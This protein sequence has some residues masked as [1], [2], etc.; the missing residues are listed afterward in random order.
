MSLLSDRLPR[1]RLG[2]LL[3]AGAGLLVCVLLLSANWARADQSG[4]WR[5]RDRWWAA[6]SQ[7]DPNAIF[8]C[9]WDDPM[10]A[11]YY[12]Q[13]VEGFRKDVTVLRPH[14]LWNDWYTDLIEDAELRAT[15]QR[16]W[17]EITR[18][19]GLKH[20]GTEQFWEGTALFAHRLA[21]HYHGRRTVY[22]LHGPYRE[23]LPGPPYFVGLTDRLY[24]LDFTR[25]NL[26]P[27]EDRSEPIVGFDG[28]IQLLSLEFSNPTPGNGDLVE[29]RARW[30]LDQP[31][32]GALFAVELT[33]EAAAERERSRL[34]A[35]GEFVQGFPVLYG[36]WGLPASPPGT[37]Y[38]QRGALVI[39]SN[40]PAGRYRMR[41]GFAQAYPPHYQDWREV[42]GVTI[43]LRPPLRPLPANGP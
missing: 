28:G 29:F 11:A 4:V 22:A 23:T 7:M 8:V 24:R 16:L 17:R 2:Y 36:Q 39:P 35:K 5:H 26:Q 33:P 27:I 37:A 10:F 40:A 38:E 43:E 15:S 6:L 32:P 21:Q 1:R 34:T 9:E 3:S 42:D 13:H 20:P 12:L 25:P 14:G 31:L 18:Q 41:V 30:R 19:Y